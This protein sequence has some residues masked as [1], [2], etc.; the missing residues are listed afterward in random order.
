V[1]SARA[2]SAEDNSF[3]FVDASKKAVSLQKVT[4]FSMSNASAYLAGV[5]MGCCLI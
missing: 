4:A 5:A 2:L 3:I 1:A